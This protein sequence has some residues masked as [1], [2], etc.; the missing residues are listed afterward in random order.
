M[1]SGVGKSVAD[2]QASP[3]PNSSASASEESAVRH[4]RNSQILQELYRVVWLSDPASPAEFGNWLDSI[5]QGASF[6]GVYNAFTH[7]DGQRGRESDSQTAASRAAVQAFAE[8][9]ALLMM[10]LKELP[11]VRSL[12]AAPLSTINPFE[13]AK[14]GVI[15]FNGKK[16]APLQKPNLQ[17]VTA[18][19]A[20]KFNKASV[21]T[22]KRVLGDWALRVM[23]E[24][25]EQSP[26]ALWDWYAGF[27]SRCAAMKV[28]FGLKLRNEPS[29]EFHRSWAEQN[30]QD[31]LHWE[32][33]NRLHRILNEA[34][35]KQ[36]EGGSS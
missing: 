1:T 33:L 21:F 5:D 6:E 31:L 10:E 12:D 28:D 34:H 27:A 18:S 3:E 30:T 19:V 29:K 14:P 2:P 13:E 17:E 11:E 15:E 16:G 8:Q 24:R 32:V 9:M 4:A 25:K 7:S 20:Q 23:A 22:L 36:A 26:Q 35:K